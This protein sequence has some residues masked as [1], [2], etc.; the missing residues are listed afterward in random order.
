M[1]SGS[2][3]K[4]RGT[5]AFRLTLWYAGIF[6]VT[7]AVA[8]AFFYYLVTQALRS[9]TDQDLLAD[10]RSF[11]SV[12]LLQG[13]EAVKRQ[14]LLESHAAGEKKIFV[15]LLYPDGRVFSSSNMSYFR[16]IP[17]SRDAIARMLSQEEPVFATVSS[18]DHQHEIRVVYALLGP[19]LVIH[20]GQAM[21]GLTRFI[22]AYRRIFLLTMAALF[23]VAVGVGWFMARRAT[24]GV[25]R[26]T[27][28]AL[29]ISEGRLDE[30]VPLGRSGDE[31]D[32]LA[33]TFNLMLDRIQ[34][35]VAGIRE[36]SDN[37]A[38]DLKTPITRIRGQ[39]EL[40]LASNGPLEDL[41]GT[42][43][44]ECDRL[45]AMIDAM[46]F[47][48]RTEAGVSRPERRPLDLSELVRNACEL[49]RSLAEDK[50]IR[51]TC[52]AT[53]RLVV[54]GDSP[55]VQRMVG[56]LLEN[57]IKYTSEGGLVEVLLSKREGEDRAALSVCDTGPGIPASDLPHIFER[58][59][60]GDP[61][62]SQPGA[63]L[64]LSFALAVARAHGG[65]ITV[66]S[67]PEGSTFTA[68]LPTT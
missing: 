38:H 44:E 46:L 17:I 55:L 31:I 61:S 42:A 56:N 63:G 20:V 21:E 66:R 27:R 67:L 51:L 11:S 19:G 5:L 36:M 34:L 54:P 58:F 49:F 28:T 7:A 45:L 50:R 18:P 10:V 24:A 47:I 53:D 26:V 4:L 40:A 52:S 68:Y 35:L 64:G 30:R 32:R 1:P 62:R 6:L 43:V 39:A 37:I 65:D 59:Y 15:Q 2:R 41:A 12:M 60:R 16:N 57:A 48:S 29:R 33:T 8:F 14:A 23:M 3:L 9:R 22:D 25:A 13:V